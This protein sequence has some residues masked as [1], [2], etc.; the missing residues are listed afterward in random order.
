MIK[1]NAISMPNDLAEIVA[2]W[3]DIS[4]DQKAQILAIVKAE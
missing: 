2:A 1:D 4:P 3:P